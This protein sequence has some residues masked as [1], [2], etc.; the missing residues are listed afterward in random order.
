M[1][2]TFGNRLDSEKIRIEKEYVAERTLQAGRT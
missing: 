1:N 2:D